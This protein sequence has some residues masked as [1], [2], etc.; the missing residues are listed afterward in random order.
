M[1]DMDEREWSEEAVEQF[2]EEFKRLNA[3]PASM[4][5]VGG[6]MPTH[7]PLASHIGLRPVMRPHET[8]PLDTLE[9]PMQFIA[10]LN[11]TEAPYLPEVLKQY[12]L[13]T[14]F[15]AE[16]CIQQRFAQGSWT[17]RAYPT[18]A[19]LIPVEAPNQPW[20]WMRGFECQWQMI[21]DYPAYDDAQLRLPDGLS[22]EDD[23][24]EEIHGFNVARS[25]VG[26]F[27][28]TI[29]HAVEFV[30]ATQTPD[31]WQRDDS[32]PF[33]FQINSEEKARL[34]WADNGTLYVGKRTG[35]DEWF[36]SC[37]FY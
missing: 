25:K 28:S 15:V 36:A 26:G 23:L 35:T 14:I 33:V 17:L 12:A 11:L 19:D 18:L 16:D 5:Q 4:L 10:Q 9:R 32:P 21:T 30:S 3:R 7:R 27:A 29:Q 22:L 8:W 1:P 6:V 24:P 20:H 31:D 37:Q 2:L 34:M 13:L